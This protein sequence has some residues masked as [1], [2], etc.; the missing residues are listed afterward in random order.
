MISLRERVPSTDSLNIG[1][2]DMENFNIE[3]LT[4]VMQASISPVALISGMGLMILSQTNRFSRVT[5]RLRELI[6]QRRTA[7]ATAAS[8]ER[9]IKIFLKRARILQAAIGFAA[10]CVFLAGLLVLM[11][12]GI[13]VLNLRLHLVVLL[14]FALSLV[15]LIVSV[16]LFLR[17]THLSLL[18]IEQEVSGASEETSTELKT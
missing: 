16:A 5:E 8:V 1:C 12:F 7:R 17:D 14:A 3:H 11:M 13:A 2:E 9:Q 18:A 10:G 6:R 4:R 15:C